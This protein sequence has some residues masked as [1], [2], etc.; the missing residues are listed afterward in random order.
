MAARI[1]RRL[2]ACGPVVLVL[3]TTF[4]R[5][6]TPTQ[7]VVEISTDAPSCDR[8]T[9]GIYVASTSAATDLG[10]L[11][12]V[13]KSGCERAGFIGSAVFLPTGSDDE[14]FALKVV[15]AV[16]V[17]LED[18]RR[19]SESCIVE[20]RAVRYARGEIVRV[21][22]SM[23]QQCIGVV[24]AGTDRCQGGA[25]VPCSDCVDKGGIDAAPDVRS[26][27]AGPGDAGGDAGPPG[28]S[29]KDVCPDACDGKV[30]KRTCTN[31][32]GVVCPAGL[33]CEVTCMTA[34]S[35]TNIDCG[36]ATSCKVTCGGAV[37]A[38]AGIRCD[39]PTCTIACNNDRTCTG[40]IT[41]AGGSTT[42]ACTGTACSGDFACCADKCTFNCPGADNCKGLL[43]C[44]DAGPSCHSTGPTPT[45]CSDQCR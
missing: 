7:L 11:P 33:P 34:G 4:V 43:C 5:C 10:D 26:D 20:R 2:I 30:C 35:C 13:S 22:I 6:R 29:C 14:A 40:L 9:T 15:T 12:V 45:T 18:C 37:S 38:C 41:T 39:A 25:C 21:G 17:S 31:C 19:G 44:A 3:A 8:L 24:C 27:A 16:G 1:A 36:D 23:D 32:T 42:L 28:P